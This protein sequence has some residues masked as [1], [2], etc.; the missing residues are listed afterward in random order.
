[1]QLSVE[2]IRTSVTRLAPQN[3]VD[4]D[5]SQRW[6]EA[7]GPLDSQALSTF[8]A[9]DMLACRLDLKRRKMT[10][11]LYGLGILLAIALWTAL[12]GVA[13][14]WMTAAYLTFLAS[15]VLVLKRLRQSDLADDQ[16]DYRFLAETLR[17][18]NYW[19]LLDASPENDQPS[20]GPDDDASGVR[21][22]VLTSLLSQQAIEI[23]WIR[24]ALRICGSDPTPVRLARDSRARLLHFWVQDQHTYFLKTAKKYEKQKRQL[25]TVA[26]ACGLIGL[27]AASCVILIDQGFLDREW[28]HMCAI[29]AAVLPAISLLL[30][31]YSDR[32]ALQAQAKNMTRMSA[33]FG[34]FLYRLNK[35]RPNTMPR[36][37]EI[38][39]LGEEALTESINWL[40]LRRSRP[41]SMPT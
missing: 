10:K 12:D 34:R 30:Q 22:Q 19:R 32:M 3:G 24:E 17:I 5:L 35:N 40:V 15:I 6:L 16:L 36:A 11:L 25:G 33:V 14:L 2:D 21:Y 27:V 8:G 1:M 23:G 13:Q 31:S 41:A 18:Q 28:R 38:H 20:D 9:A 29:S 39:A 37:Q 26:I 7:L 4:E